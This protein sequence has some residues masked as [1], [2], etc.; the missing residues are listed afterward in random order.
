MAL[1]LHLYRPQ[2]TD[3]ELLE[4]TFVAREG[5]LEEVLE[6]LE[7][8]VPGGSRQHYL[9]IGPRGIGKTNLLRLVEH[10]VR[11][12]PGLR[13]KWLPVALPE[14]FYR[15]STVSDL[16]LETLRALADETSM[17]DLAQ[18][19][20]AV[21]YDDDDRRVN[22][23]CLDAFRLFHRQ[24]GRGILLVIENLDRLLERQVKKR[25]E[26]H[27]LRKILIE[28]D[29]LLVL[30][31][32]PSFL[33]AVTRPEEPFFEFFKVRPI[34]ELTPGEQ[35]ELLS[36]LA[37]VESNTAFAAYLK[38]FRSRLRALY[39]LT[40]GNP[41]LT[42]MLYDLVAHQEVSSVHSELD[43][44]LDQLTPFYQDRMGDVSQ[45]A[46]KVLEAIAI[47]PEGST[48]TELAGEL[49]MQPKV[50]R[51]VLSRLERS[52][53]VRRE[54]RR[55]KRTVYILPERFFRIWHQ[56]NHSRAVRG[57]IQYLLEFFSSWYAS[58][59]ERDQI[60]DELTAG[61]ARGLREGDERRADDLAEYMK[62]VVAI[63][64]GGERLERI[65]E[66]L[67]HVHTAEGQVPVARQLAALDREYHGDNEYLVLKGRFL[68]DELGQYDAALA[69]FEEAIERNKNDI[70]P[71]F[72]RAVALDKTGRVEEAGRTYRA[73]AVL[74]SGAA[75]GE[76]GQDTTPLL[77]QV[78]RE[79]SDESLVR[80]AAYLLG[81][82][83]EPAAALE[84]LPVIRTAVAPW[85][86]QHCATALGRLG[87]GRGVEPLI[88]ALNDP[89]DNV[90][91]SAA[92]ALGRIAA[93][94]SVSGQHRV[95]DTISEGFAD[96]PQGL[97]LQILRGLLRAI[98]GS[99]DLDLIQ[100]G[101]EVLACEIDAPR[102]FWLPYEIALEH[103]ASGRDPAVLERQ[104][105]EMRE[106]VELLVGSFEEGD[107]AALA[108]E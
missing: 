34:A 39:H 21:R 69:V 28:E 5:L 18:V 12:R 1:A 89:A 45:Q 52:G 80:I 13:R 94:I 31:A 74:L 92:A 76:E 57:R 71:L 77:L 35:Q 82:T 107:L 55:A 16:L 61:L 6:R 27:L 4:K 86:R 19:Y 49:R 91:G 83:A 46:A 67:R 2:R 20:E 75:G 66:Q 93:G 70:L 9:F 22:D 3:P 33:D 81:R 38:R 42:I 15:V 50:V 14:D 44:L 54:E 23:R 79:S 88:Q 68:A 63:S 105:P 99:G 102:A 43:L 41:R 25:K 90:R 51:A 32:S 36:K 30:C 78:L 56:M 96:L 24:T 65:F 87:S 59:E 73:A 47:L 101:I 40:G 100:R 72:N 29:W 8:W 11:T 62:Y 26:A 37:A 98:F 106:A 60:W 48:P 108:A 104:Q 85:R 95:L 17:E 53:Y 7:S 103:L 97:K 58:R 64:E 84:I 10:R